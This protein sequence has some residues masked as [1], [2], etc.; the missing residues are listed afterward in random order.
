[1]F[2]HG[3]IKKNKIISIVESYDGIIFS[4]RAIVF[5]LALVGR[6]YFIEEKLRKRTYRGPL[7]N[8]EDRLRDPLML[9][10]RKLKFFE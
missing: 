5:F 1:M 9:E 2:I 3:L 6:L 8:R 7:I 4:E 10:R